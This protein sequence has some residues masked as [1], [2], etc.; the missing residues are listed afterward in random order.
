MLVWICR[1]PLPLGVWEWLRFV[2]VAFPGLFFYLICGHPRYGCSL[3]FRFC[4]HVTYVLVMLAC[5]DGVKGP[6]SLF[7]LTIRRWFLC[8]NSSFHVV[9]F[10]NCAIIM[11]LFVSNLSFF[12]WLGT[13][14]LCDCDISWVTSFILLWIPNHRT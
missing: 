1:F 4:F 8:Y 2:I 9:G 14:V 10:C 13:V 11:L 7:L 12:L 3:C 5:F 6:Q